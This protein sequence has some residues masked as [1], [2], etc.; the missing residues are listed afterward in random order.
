MQQWAVGK[1]KKKTTK[2]QQ[3]MKELLSVPTKCQL[4][5][6]SMHI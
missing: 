3:R 4:V 2:K 6:F 1:K 5:R